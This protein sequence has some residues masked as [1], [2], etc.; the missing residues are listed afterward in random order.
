MGLVK[1]HFLMVFFAAFAFLAA[2]GY[3]L[4]ARR[5]HMVDNYRTA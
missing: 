5:Y 4:C 2:L 3:G 1:R